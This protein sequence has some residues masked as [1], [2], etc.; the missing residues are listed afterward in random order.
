M[1]PRGER[2]GEGSRHF[3]RA[4]SIQ[5]A[6]AMTRLLPPHWPEYLIEMT[7]LATFMASAAMFATVLQHP[8]SPLSSWMAAGVAGRVPMAAAMALT[9][10]ALI[11]SPWGRRS[12]AHMN[13]AVTITFLRLRKIAVRDAAGYVLAQFVGGCAGI[14]TATTLLAQL[15]A[16]PSVNYVATLPGP[17][18]VLV[19]VVAEAA[20]S[21]GLMLTVLHLSN[22]PR[23][24]RY[25]GT[26]AGLLVFAYITFEAP[27]S[28]MS[29]N[30]AR[31]LG[32]ALLTGSL[33]SLW[34]YFVGPLAG[35]LAAAELY[36]RR[37]GWSR[38]LCAKLHHSPAHPCIFRCRFG[39]QPEVRP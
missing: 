36:V 6:T 39:A 19:A 11:Y 37:H 38:V 7:S 25:T 30:P 35:M 34:I 26:A 10:M 28:G 3:R 33:G 2:Y 22:H 27:L 16:D 21:F 13:P 12:G 14:A 32:P 9:A 31:S 23:F 20:I 4:R 1:P 5:I 24:N 8:S 17:T 15:P 29:M 18:G